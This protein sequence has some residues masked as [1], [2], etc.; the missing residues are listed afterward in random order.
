MDSPPCPY[1]IFKRQ[2][3]SR[4]LFQKSMQAMTYFVH[5]IK[6]LVFLLF[7]YKKLNL[8]ILISH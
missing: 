8:S 3:S 5:F 1:S 6:N 7:Y 2:S 4:P